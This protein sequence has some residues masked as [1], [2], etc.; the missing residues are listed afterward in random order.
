MKSKI[1]ESNSF[2]PLAERQN[3]HFLHRRALFALVLNPW[4]RWR[5]ILLGKKMFFPFFAYW[6]LFAKLSFSRDDLRNS[7]LIW[8]IKIA[9]RYCND[10]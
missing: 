6:S 1:S 8:L 2:S 3:Q 5:R 10:N 7:L 4:S 9:F